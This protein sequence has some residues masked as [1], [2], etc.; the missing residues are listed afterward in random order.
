MMEGW[1]P[2]PEYKDSGVPWLGEIPSHWEILRSGLLFREV[3]D[4][5]HPDLEL[6]SIDRFKGIIKQHETG[7]KERASEDRSIYKRIKKG[8]LGYNL[9][10]AFM[11]SVGISPHDGIL[12]PAYAVGRPQKPMNPLFYHYLYRTPIYTGEF[13]CCSYG[14]MYE[15]NRLYNERFKPIPAPYPSLIEQDQ[16]VRTIQYFE[17][18]IK[19][20][21]TKKRKTI[22]L[23]NEQKQAIIHQAVTRGLD[24]SVPMKPSGIEWL[25][26]IPEHWDITK[27]RNLIFG[28]EQGWSPDC[29]SKPAE[30]DEWGVLKVGCVNYGIF[31]EKEN[32]TLPK[33]TK[34]LSEYEIHPGDLLISR[35]N[36]LELLG[37]CSYVYN[38]R[39]KLILCDKL[40]RINYNNNIID[41]E[42][43]C[44]FLNSIIARYQMEREAT[45]ASNSMK[46]IV[47][48]TIQ[49]VVLPFPQLNEQYSIVN[50]LKLET[51]RIQNIISITSRNISLLNEYRTRLIT[52][53]VTGKL[54]VR[55]I[56]AT[57]PNIEDIPLDIPTDEEPEEE[58]IAEEE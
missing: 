20:Y 38:V 40:Y 19:D 54:D 39:P 24:P 17:F 55:S 41:P 12:S 51:N 29:E 25:G 15:R 13:D 28:I 56:A 43:L 9:M 44:Y 11:G 53:I 5:G 57:L 4:T 2:Y 49:N 50:N 6:L 3:V 10:N 27:I 14:I 23:L 16:I 26:E 42:Y 47:Q 31:N 30:I 58:Y 8:D 33:R 48:G 36:S 46:N 22:D 7:R 35:A 18:L 52:D 21:I 32:K 45:G 1:Q 34:P 37:S